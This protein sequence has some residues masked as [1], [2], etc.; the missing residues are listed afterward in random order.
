MNNIKL[1][2]S[3]RMLLITQIRTDAMQEALDVFTE[4]TPL[5][6]FKWD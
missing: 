2:E 4:E 5:S 3:E 1:K 6:A